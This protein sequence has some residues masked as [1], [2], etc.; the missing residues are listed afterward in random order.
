MEYKIIRNTDSD[1]LFVVSGELKSYS[2]T[3]IE[4][5]IN[6]LIAANPNILIAFDFS[7]LSYIDSQGIRVLVIAGKH[8]YSLGKNLVLKKVDYKVKHILD[9]ASLHFLEYAD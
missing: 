9:L 3:E 8:N 4:K 1:T 5:S 6:D 2:I 7:E